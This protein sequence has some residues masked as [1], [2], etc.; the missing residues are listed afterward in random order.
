[1]FFRLPS[2]SIAVFLALSSA[3]VDSAPIALAPVV[4]GSWAAGSG[5]QAEFRAIDSGWRGSTVHWNEATL[6][7]SPTPGAGYSP[8]GSFDWGTGIW[9]LND[10]A[11]VQSGDVAAIASWSG[12][13]ARIEQAN[14]QYRDAWGSS[15]WGD[16][17]P[18]PDDVPAENWTAYYTGYL[19]ITDADRYNF[20]VLYDDGFF[21]RI[22]GADDQ[23]VEISS[24]FILTARERLGFDE[25][26][27]LSE[28]L[29]RFELGAYN[30][31]QAGVVQLAWQRGEG[32][33]ET[34]PTGNLVT[35][36]TRIPL[37]GTLAMIALGGVG[38]VASRKRSLR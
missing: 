30:R 31:L 23:L 3:V 4:A 35:D 22:H 20:G 21:L 6:S 32:A 25:D 26:L 18:M 1:M 38:F 16:V 37:P 34:V 7:Y 29:Y 28:G 5:A 17:S 24:D 10:W 33:W 27:L 12:T 15:D 13:V 9:G 19:R 14:Q 11:R 8:V 36:P 2:I